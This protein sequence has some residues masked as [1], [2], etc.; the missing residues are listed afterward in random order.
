M[1][2][3][4]LLDDVRRRL[5]DAGLRGSFLVRDLDT[6]AEVAIDPGAELPLASLAKIPLAIAVLERIREGRLDGAAPVDVAPV[7][8]VVPG[9]MGLSRFR[10]PARI[11][12]EDLVYLSTA[13]SDS[14]AADALFD[15]VPPEAV[16]RTLEALGIGDLAVRHRMAP[17]TETPAEVFGADEA[18]LAQALAIGA[19]DQDRG[20]PVAQL[21][22]ARAN[23]GTARA[24]GALLS[25][26]WLP[27]RLDP[28][29]AAS[30]RELMA[31]NVV[32]HR[33]APEF[34]ADNMTWSSKTGTLLN[35][36]HEIG[37]VEHAD[38][39]RIAVAALTASSVPAAAQPAAEAELAGVARQLHDHLRDPEPRRRGGA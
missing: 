37:V 34:T 10:H 35:L 15:L 4:A 24:C 19:G 17:L 16:M 28:G 33:L 26:L 7:E 22:V 23:T 32:R 38:G 18:H 2:T 12:V 5:A 31:A 9:P 11:A 39:Q 36:R 27:T 14:A 25:E 1:S 13:V 3:L 8:V 6:G 21:D 20:H 30:V 29:T